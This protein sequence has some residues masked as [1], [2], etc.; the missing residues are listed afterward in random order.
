MRTLVGSLLYTEQGTTLLWWSE[1][2]T[3]NKNKKNN[4][5]TPLPPKTTPTP[6]TCR[7]HTCAQEGL[8]YTHLSVDKACVL[9][10]VNLAVQPVA[11]PISLP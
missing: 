1:P 10:C 7:V 6:N 2:K 11:A 8:I 4:N 3:T 9:F 5:A